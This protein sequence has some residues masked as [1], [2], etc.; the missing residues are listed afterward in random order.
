MEFKGTKGEWKYFVKHRGSTKD[1]LIQVVLPNKMVLQV[2]RISDDDCTEPS[3]C[4]AEEH[5]NAQLI[6]AAPELLEALQFLWKEY[7]E[8][9][10]LDGSD[11]N[12]INESYGIEKAIKKALGQ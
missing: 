5:A 4:C 1:S 10:G 6:S 7:K 11:L 8:N 3:C 12:F 9:S 2:G